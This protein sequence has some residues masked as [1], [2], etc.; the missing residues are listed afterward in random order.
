MTFRRRVSLSVQLIRLCSLMNHM[1]LFNLAHIWC[2]YLGKN[3]YPLYMM[4]VVL[5]KRVFIGFDP[6]I[7]KNQVGWC[8]EGDH[9][10]ASGGGIRRRRWW[11]DAW[12]TRIYW[13]WVFYIH[14][15]L[16][17]CKYD[18]SHLYRPTAPE[19]LPTEV[20]KGWC[21]L[22]LIRLLPKK[23][24]HILPKRKTQHSCHGYIAQ[25]TMVIS[26]TSRILHQHGFCHA[27]CHCVHHIHT[28]IAVTSIWRNNIV[29]RY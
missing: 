27:V 12:Q 24:P 20:I 11:M 23:V 10:L 2:E 9:M 17:H 18:A 14:N 7:K 28:C 29:M 25:I 6:C 26:H 3:M 5:S 13:K 15:T 22:R 21:M 8:D 1:K 19:H 4:W 16:L